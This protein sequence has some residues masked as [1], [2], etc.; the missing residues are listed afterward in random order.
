MN[1]AC[2]RRPANS[3]G[4]V[5]TTHQRAALGLRQLLEDFGLLVFRQIFED[6]YRVVGFQ[7]AY[8][9]CNGLGWQLLENFL[10]NRVVHFGQRGEVEIDTKQFDKA[11]PL[12]WR[13]APRLGRPCR[14]HAG[15]RPAHAD[16]RRPPFRSCGRRF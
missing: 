16:R 2:M 4:V 12:F 9:L 11:L 13:Q 1:S 6:R 10:A 14:I 15:H 7:F 5:E 3:S 8:A